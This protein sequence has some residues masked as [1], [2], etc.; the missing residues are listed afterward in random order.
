MKLFILGILSLLLMPL[1]LAE[2]PPTIKTKLSFVG[3]RTPPSLKHIIINQ[4]P[5]NRARLLC[6]SVAP[7]ITYEG[8][9]NIAIFDE[10]SMGPDAAPLCELQLKTNS[11]ETIILLIGDPLNSSRR[12][13]AIV[14]PVNDSKFPGGSRLVYNFSKHP[15]R[16]TLARL[17]FKR[18]SKQNIYFRVKSGKT[19]L[20]KA[21][22]AEHL[23]PLGILLQ[24]QNKQK[25]T[26]FKDSRWFHNANKRSLV[27]IIPSYG[28][29]GVQVKIVED[30]L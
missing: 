20:I 27:F 1:A 17:P 24:W 16:G 19:Q 4:K 7:P 11:P 14:V 6:N 10:K 3:F 12:L 23:E 30:V 28:E 18:S 25:W 9:P 5:E 29:T 8:S 13:K 22:P 21:M 2:S 15:V 26:T